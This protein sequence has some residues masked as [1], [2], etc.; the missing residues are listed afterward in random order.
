MSE[1]KFEQRIDQKGFPALFAVAE[2]PPEPVVEETAK[3]DEGVEISAGHEVYGKL[4]EP[5][6]T[7]LKRVTEANEPTHVEIS[8][9]G[10]MAVISVTK[11]G[12]VLTNLTLPT[13]ATDPQI[14]NELAYSLRRPR[15][16]KPDGVDDREW[17]RRVDA[18]RDAAREMDFQ[19]EADLREFLQGRASDPDLVDLEAFRRDVDEQR[20]DDLI[21]ILDYNLREKVNGMRRSRRWVR[22]VAPKG[23]TQRVF[24]SLEDDD[25]LTVAGRLER[26]GWK[27][28]DLIDHVI[29]RVA[30]EERRGAIISRFTG[31][32]S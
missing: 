14:V 29:G 17:E 2:A 10:D 19:S 3:T 8:E 31:G 18:I 11:D 27:K 12:E 7:M 20:V 21:D 15:T 23:W 5:S 4:A 32:A 9:D 13:T 25:I 24:A 6:K 1:M 16:G 30:N 22:L 28:H 26:R